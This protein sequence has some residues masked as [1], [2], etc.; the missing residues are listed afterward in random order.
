MGT[1]SNVISRLDI[2]QNE[3]SATNQQFKKSLSTIT[4]KNPRTIRRWY[5][6]E[7]CIQD[8]DLNKIAVH[9]GHHENWLKFGAHNNSPSLIDEIM[10]SNHYGAVI[11]KDGAAEKMNHKFIDMMKLTKLTLDA[12]EACKH[13]LSLQTDETVGLCEISGQIAMQSGSHHHT[14]VMVMGDD[15][16]HTVDVTTLNIN[17]GRVLRIIADKGL[18]P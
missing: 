3:I 13:V 14:M 8:I 5:S 1:K 4:G 11:M 10:T 15:K 16:S 18:T 12:D 2:I 7:A 17:N 9:F 6:L